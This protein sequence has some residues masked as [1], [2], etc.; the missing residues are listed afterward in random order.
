MKFALIY[1]VDL[2]FL[3]IS[4]KS[5]LTRNFETM[6]QGGPIALYTE[7]CSGRVR[8]RKNK[9]VVKSIGATT[10]ARFGSFS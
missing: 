5:I 6:K 4:V 10:S 1:C 9:A 3:Q 7:G 2:Y 8:Q